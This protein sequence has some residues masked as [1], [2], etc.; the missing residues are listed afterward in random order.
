MRASGIPVGRYSQTPTYPHIDPL[1][2]PI[3]TPFLNQKTPECMRRIRDN[4]E[5]ES[6]ENAYK[7]YDN[8]SDQK[9]SRDYVQAFDADLQRNLEEIVRQIADE[10]WQPKGYK[11]K[12]IFERKRRQLAK[13]PIEDHVLESATILPYEK[14]IYDYSTWRAPAVKPGMGTHG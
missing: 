12:I 6:L 2:D 14:S 11:K 7:A 9:H 4:R 13:A 3:E 1:L 10:S 8:Y 5:N